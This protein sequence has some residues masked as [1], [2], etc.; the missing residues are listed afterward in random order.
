MEFLERSAAISG[1]RWAA[2][3]GGES[4]RIRMRGLTALCLFAGLLASTAVDA[5]PEPKAQFV[6]LGTAGGPLTRVKRS[7]PANAIVVGD[8]IYLFDTG[9]GVQRQLAAA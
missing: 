6:T 7:E 4:M 2:V 1:H 9:D 8:A 3:Y 5:Q